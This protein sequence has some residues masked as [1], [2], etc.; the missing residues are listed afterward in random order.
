M[1]D[2]GVNFI[3][4]SFKDDLDKVIQSAQV[5]GVEKMIVTGTSVDVSLKSAELA[6]KYPGVLYSTAGIHPHD[7]KTFDDQSIDELRQLL[8][9]EEVVAVGE[10]GL[11]F[12][13]NFSPRDIQQECFRQQ[14]GLAVE[15]GRA[16]FLHQRE[17]HAELMAILAGF[18]LTDIP[19]VVHCFTGTEEE[20]L[21]I[22]AA[23]FHIGITGW[24]CDE[25]RGFHL[26]DFV[27]KIPLDRLMIETD[28]P[29]LLPRNRR[30]KPARN[31][32][33]PAFLAHIADE[34]ARCFG[35][36]R[37]EFNKAVTATTLK[38]FGLK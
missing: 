2:I 8:L 32:N 30:P 13:R 34:I 9:R 1:I 35:L 36:S 23:G 29:Y 25:R 21:D 22:L 20:A 38:F 26:K 19:V 11:D 31:R 14:V 6:A 16:L 7:A 10:C 33:E 3:N 37:E 15:T 17:A 28:S 12:N 24:I 5:A 27:G 18:N 4:R